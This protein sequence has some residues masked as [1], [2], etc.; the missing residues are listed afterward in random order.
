MVPS[1]HRYV[2]GLWLTMCLP[3][4]SRSH[5]SPSHCKVFTT[6]SVSLRPPLSLLWHCPGI[7]VT[8]H[9]GST[10]QEQVWSQQLTNM[11]F[12]DVIR[13][14]WWPGLETARWERKDGKS[15][16]AGRQRINTINSFF[17]M[18][19]NIFM[20]YLH[21]FRSL[22]GEKLQWHFLPNWSCTVHLLLWPI[23]A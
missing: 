12:P 21:V 4:T 10:L 16:C 15:F 17:R 9:L 23:R 13:S 19:C 22:H 6:A 8:F 1:S 11:D 3:W 5:W 2:G 20:S 18:T 7:L 14:V